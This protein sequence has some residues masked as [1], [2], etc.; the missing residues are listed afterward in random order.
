LE[1]VHSVDAAA[2]GSTRE[3]RIME[4]QMERTGR[5]YRCPGPGFN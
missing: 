1:K 3:A 5:R 2:A 4:M